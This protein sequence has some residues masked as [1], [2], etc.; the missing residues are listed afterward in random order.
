MDD[1]R[2]HRFLNNFMILL[3]AMGLSAFFVSMCHL[4]AICF[5]YQRITHQNPPQR[6]PTPPAT[7]STAVQMIPTHTYHRKRVDG[8]VV[9]GDGD[10]GGTCVVCLGEFE[11][12]EKLR[13]LPECMHCFHVACIDTWLCSHSSC[14]VCRSIAAPPLGVLHSEHDLND[15]YEH[16]IHMTQFSVVQNGFVLRG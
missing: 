16:S 14:P 4:I 2:G 1:D 8:G 9:S 5:W 11:E 10:E 12:G 6:H 3:L 15:A 13:R 7:A